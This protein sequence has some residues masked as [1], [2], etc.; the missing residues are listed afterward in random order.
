MF[1][2]AFGGFQGTSSSG[3]GRR[4]GGGFQV[5]NSGRSLDERRSG[6]PNGEGMTDCRTSAGDEMQENVVNQMDQA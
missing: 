5:G 6:D 2:T 3:V 1:P 4:V